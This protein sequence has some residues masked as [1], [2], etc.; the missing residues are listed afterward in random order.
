[1]A[2][3]S[4]IAARSRPRSTPRPGPR[5]RAPTQILGPQYVISAGEHDL[6]DNILHAFFRGPIAARPFAASSFSWC[7]V[8]RSRRRSGR[9]GQRRPC[10]S[11]EHR[12]E[13]AARPAHEFRGGRGHLVGKPIPSWPIS[14]D[15]HARLGVCAARPRIARSPIRAPAP[16]PA[17]APGR[18]LNAPR[19]R[20]PRGA[21]PG[22]AGRPDHVHP[23]RPAHSLTMRSHTRGGAA[24]PAVSAST[25]TSPRSTRDASERDAAM[26]LVA[27]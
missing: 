24:L 18:A 5:A 8:P 7:Q 4:R 15:E 16:M 9:A 26:Y 14:D 22:E 27:L 20:G 23:R 13:P 6:T 17:T 25:S 1:M 3:P 19:G 12:G 10:G 21:P 2:S 11:I